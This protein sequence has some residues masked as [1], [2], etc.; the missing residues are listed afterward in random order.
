MKRISMKYLVLAAAALFLVTVGLGAARGSGTTS[1]VTEASTGFLYAVD[2][3]S[4]H[5]NLEYSD[6]FNDNSRSTLP[7][8]LLID[9]PAHPLDLSVGKTG[10]AESGGY[11]LLEGGGGTSSAVSSIEP[12]QI[13]S[14]EAEEFVRGALAGTVR[15]TVVLN[16]PIPDGGAGETTITVSFAAAVPAL[17]STCSAGYGVFVAGA[18]EDTAT[19]A[20]S[21]LKVAAVDA[22]TVALSFVDQ[23]SKVL[24]RAV[25][26]E[27]YNRV[28]ENLVI[29]LTVDHLDDTVTP[30]YSVDGGATFSKFE[31]GA[32][33]RVYTEA[34]GSDIYAGILGEGPAP[35]PPPAAPASHLALLA[36][37]LLIGTATVFVMF[38]VR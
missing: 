30:S 18:N 23:D 14:A 7:S 25:I 24:G 28:P 17:S 11:L 21:Y 10:T 34:I 20:G 8:S 15:D 13:E 1:A 4:V 2:D 16:Q 35:A 31:D 29:R 3:F 22:N 36:S 33:N 38:R 37:A 12:G 6:D 27:F 26:D 5:G 19:F 32:S 9:A